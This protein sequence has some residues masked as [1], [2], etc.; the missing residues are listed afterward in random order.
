MHAT[1]PRDGG[2]G[3]HSLSLSVATDTLP[4]TTATRYHVPATAP[5]VVRYTLVN[6]SEAGI[7]NLH[8]NDPDVPS[9]AISCAGGTA[10][11]P[12]LATRQCTATVPAADG[13]RVRTVHATGTLAWFGTQA[14]ASASTGY[15]GYQAA[16]TVHELVAGASTDP[17]KPDTLAVG[18]PVQI[19]Y[20]ITNTGDVP[21]G[22]LTLHSTL[23][24]AGC[25]DVSAGTELPPGGQLVCTLAPSAANGLH[26][27]NVVA[28]AAPQ[29]TVLGGDGGLAAAPSVESSAQGAYLGLSQSNVAAHGVRSGGASG[30]GTSHG[31]GS[32][33]GGGGS[34]G[35][36]SGSSGSSGG[37]GGN[38]GATSSNS[39]ANANSNAANSNP[40]QPQS[41][42]ALNGG[43]PGAPSAHSGAGFPML[44]KRARHSLPWLMMIF[45]VVFVP[46]VVRLARANRSSD[47]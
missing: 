44:L 5:V 28:S 20:Q 36:G 23:D 12:P 10:L 18:A 39:N 13:S 38:S 29:I 46:V 8:V 7:L 14:S 27:D 11:L 40:A 19:S 4:G 41:G 47:R 33:G 34:H 15:V 1:V 37:H 31:S 24:G 32:R 6:S 30:D 21:L 22:G 42:L 45:L 35:A 9:A 2:A 25:T 43:G 17:G 3:P 16:L 26:V